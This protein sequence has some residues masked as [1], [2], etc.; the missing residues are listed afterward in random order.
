MHRQLRRLNCEDLS[1]ADPRDLEDR[2]AFF[3]KKLDEV[4]TALKEKH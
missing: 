3:E 1:E 4:K 2:Q